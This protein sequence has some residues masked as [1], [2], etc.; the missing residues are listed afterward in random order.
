MG[1]L[2]WVGNTLLPRWFVFAAIALIALALVSAFIW[3]M[4]D[5]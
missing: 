3:L 4:Y 5:G 2:I 1:D